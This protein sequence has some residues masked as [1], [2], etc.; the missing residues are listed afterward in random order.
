MS[1]PVFSS[2]VT[3]VI[4]FAG[5][6]IVGGR[7]GS[8]I[9]DIPFTVA[10][11]LIASTLECFLILPNHMATPLP[12]SVAIPGTMRRSRGREPGLRLAA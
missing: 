6:V 7:F 5:L 9:A 11:V 8:L 2:T 4:A 12:M 10:A 1:A 3:T